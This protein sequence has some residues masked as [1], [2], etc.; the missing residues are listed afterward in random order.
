MSLIIGKRL[1][2]LSLIKVVE[3]RLFLFSS[4]KSSHNDFPLENKK[5]LV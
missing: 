1:V 4:G 2:G 3:N 5:N